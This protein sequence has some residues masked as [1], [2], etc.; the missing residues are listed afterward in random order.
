MEESFLLGGAC[1][2]L[3]ATVRLAGSFLVSGAGEGRTMVGGGVVTL[4]LG[5]GTSS[6]GAG[7]GGRM[8]GRLAPL[9]RLP[10]RELAML[11]EELL[12]PDWLL[13]SLRWSWLSRYVSWADS[14]LLWTVTAM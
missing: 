1:S 9:T 11:S 8:G 6:R 7:M 5:R 2:S 12:H 14:V 13:T 10:V 4:A 3:G